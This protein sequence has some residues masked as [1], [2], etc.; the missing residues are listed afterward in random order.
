MCTLI[1]GSGAECWHL[2][3]NSYQDRRR[4]PSRLG[5]FNATGSGIRI[6]Y[7]K[8]RRLC[9]DCLLK[10][11]PDGFNFWSILAP[12]SGREGS[13]HGS[14][15]V[16]QQEAYQ[17][18]DNY[19]PLFQAGTIR[20][21]EPFIIPIPNVPHAKVAWQWL[22]EERRPFY[23]DQ[24]HLTEPLTPLTTR[25]AEI[26]ARIA[27]KYGI[28]F[29][30]RQVLK[31]IAQGSFSQPANLTAMT[32]QLLHPSVFLVRQAN[33]SKERRKANPSL[34][35]SGSNIPALVEMK[36]PHPATSA[37][38]PSTIP[39]T[40]SLQADDRLKRYDKGLPPIPQGLSRVPTKVGL[41]SSRK[42]PVIATTE[43]KQSKTSHYTMFLQQNE[44]I[45]EVTHPARAVSTVR[46]HEKGLKGATPSQSLLLSQRLLAKKP[47]FVSITASP[48][49]KYVRNWSQH[50]MAHFDTVAASLDP[51]VAAARKRNPVAPSGLQN[52][53]T[54]DFDKETKRDRRRSEKEALTTKVGVDETITKKYQSNGQQVTKEKKGFQVATRMNVASANAQTAWKAESA[55]NINSSAP[56]RA[57]GPS[58]DRTQN[59]TS[60]KGRELVQA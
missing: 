26:D 30:Q 51:K 15:S 40:G 27:S 28:S 59:P 45:K 38:R 50:N 34:N 2:S 33:F 13:S 5:F 14:L 44:S 16:L 41:S 48:L 10:A 32:D 31:P 25:S 17:S 42:A 9:G 52:T 18:S 35:Q 19:P 53:R 58:S 43:Q 56:A 55:K 36:L 11:V 23:I 29:Y 6:I 46:G 22:R 8:T 39:S 37:T 7:V 4:F 24:L 21:P 49:A 3:A 12:A 47:Q 54:R 60:T 20:T 1:N 57:S